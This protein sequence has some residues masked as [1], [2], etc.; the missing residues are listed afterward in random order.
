[1]ALRSRLPQCNGFGAD[2]LAVAPTVLEP[3]GAALPVCAS[4]DG[5]DQTAA[6]QVIKP[7]PPSSDWPKWR[8]ILHLN[9]RFSSCILFLY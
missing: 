3:D 5:R 7:Q 4:G 6:R 9:G 2:G 1:M 8:A